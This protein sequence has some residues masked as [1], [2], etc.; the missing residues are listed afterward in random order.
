MT[1]LMHVDEA[2]AGQPAQ[3]AEIDHAFDALNL[4]GIYFNVDSMSRHGFPWPLDA[5]EM[6][7]FWEKLAGRGIMLCIELSSG[8]TY[9]RAGYM[10]HI[11]ALGRVLDAPYAICAS[12]GDEPAG[13]VL[14]QERPLRIPRGAARRLPP[15][16]A[17]DG[18]HVSDH[19]RRGL[20]LSLSR[21]RRH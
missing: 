2:M 7:P 17:G 11:V 9:D 16:E 5:P 8:P 10:A 4:R 20:G 3:L 18:G 13:R 6:A 14:R 12:S 15:R 1:G 19:L 21:R